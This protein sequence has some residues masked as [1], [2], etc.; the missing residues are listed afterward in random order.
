MKFSTV[1]PSSLS[2]V[3]EIL[4]SDAAVAVFYSTERCAVCHALLPKMEALFAEKFPRIKF[5]HVEMHK[6]P[7]A[8]AAYSVFNAPTLL[9]FF[10]GK[11]TFRKSSNMGMGEVFEAL[12]RPYKLLFSE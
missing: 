3:K 5:L 7:E 9:V 10:E 4:S 8:A 2:N 12:H 6:L 11:E 1:Y